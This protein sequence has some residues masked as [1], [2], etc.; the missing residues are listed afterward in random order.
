M[1]KAVHNLHEY[2]YKLKDWNALNIDSM[3]KDCITD[4]KD[5]NRTESEFSAIKVLCQA[6]FTFYLSL[7]PKVFS[8]ITTKLVE[9]QN[10]ILKMI[11]KL[12][13]FL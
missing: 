9:I 1:F 7:H 4:F 13:N 3:I 5:T 8:W 2:L 10:A 12:L 11:M 6:P